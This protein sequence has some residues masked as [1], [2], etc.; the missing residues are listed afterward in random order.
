MLKDPTVSF[1]KVSAPSAFSQGT[2]LKWCFR[3]WVL[4]LWGGIS[5]APVALG[6]ILLPEMGSPGLHSRLASNRKPRLT[7]AAFFCGI[8]PDQLGGS[9]LCLLGLLLPMWPS[10]EDMANL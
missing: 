4:G 2:G 5:S 3:I 9:H 6:N 7:H 10:S 8:L 1:A